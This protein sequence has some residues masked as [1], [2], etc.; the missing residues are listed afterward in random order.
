[1]FNQRPAN[2]NPAVET[3]SAEDPG[4]PVETLA[5]TAEPDV[6][7]ARAALENFPVA[8]KVLP[9]HL[10]GHLRAIYGYARLADNLGDEYPGDRSAALD[11][12]EGELDA[13]F[14]GAPAHPVFRRLAP[15][16][17]RFGLPRT[18]FDR[19]LAANR[20]DQ[21][22]AAYANWE[23]LME[24]CE[25]SANPVGQLVLA[26]FESATPDR[27]AASDAVCSGLQVLEHLQDVGEDAR[28]GR[29]YLPADDM[30]RFGC[31]FEDLTAPEAGPDLRRLVEY[32]SA[33]A[34]EMLERGRWLAA[35]LRGYARL[36]VAGFVAGGLAGLD[37]IGAAGFEILGGTRKAGSMRLLRRYV[38]LY[39]KAVTRQRNG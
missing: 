17:S 6:V 24:Y 15:T 35:S 21:H 29:V 16:V 30:N 11:W 33:R 5:D 39:L 13:L 9:T 12:L 22:K 8:L 3:P 31:T 14:A 36:A 23:E 10:Q 4:A 19:L 28:A 2:L 38:P 26:V 25:L 32:E 37:A 34:R 7:M 27:L 20:L 18:P 1:M